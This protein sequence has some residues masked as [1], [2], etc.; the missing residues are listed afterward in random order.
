MRSCVILG[1]VFGLVLLL[2][3]CGKSDCE[4]WVDLTTECA[5]ELADE[6]REAAIQACELFEIADVAC[7]ECRESAVDQCTAEQAGGECEAACR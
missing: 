1:L 7:L 5:G 3:G 2:G 4:R 6:Q